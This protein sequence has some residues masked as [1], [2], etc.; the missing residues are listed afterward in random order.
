MDFGPRRGGLVQ[1]LGRL[2]H[3]D[4]SLRDNTPDVLPAL[5]REAGFSEAEE[6]ADEHR[7]IGSIYTY[8]A[9]P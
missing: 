7:L 6:I 8:R 4:E 1:T 2:L 5:M 3:R 9:Q